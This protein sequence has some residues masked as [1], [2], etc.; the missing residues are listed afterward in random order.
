MPEKLKKLV[1]AYEELE[2]KLGDPAVIADPKEYARLA[3]EHADQAELVAKAREYLQALEDI[4]TA[5]EMLKETSDPDDKAMLQEDISSNEERLPKLEDEIKIML[6]PGDPNDEKNTIVE[7]RAGVGGDEA[8]IFAG[9]LFQM[10]Q[11]FAQTRKW[12]IEVLSSSPGEAGGFKTIEFKVTGDKVYSVMKYESGV[13]RV[14]RVPKTESQGRIQTST[15]TVAVLPEA[16][17]IDIDI[18]DEDLRIDTYCASGPGGQGVNTTYSAVRITHLPTNTVVQSQDQRS[19]IQNRAV[20]MQ[21]LRA[22]L[23]EM[24]LEKQQAEQGAERLSQ[25][26]HGNRSEKIRTYNQPQD[27][28]TDHRIGFNATYTGV[29]EGDQLG[30]IIEAL[31]AAD[32]AE[33]LAETV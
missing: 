28:V 11:R 21:M 8:A 30:S 16:D 14:Q 15:A 25:I 20:C 29:L 7:I 5:K 2:Q 6:I 27:R 4:E 13:H 26:G 3:K 22:R 24:E 33:K 12:K 17:E 19:Q 9:D 10:Y 23:Y 18:K 31:A 32:R 1:A